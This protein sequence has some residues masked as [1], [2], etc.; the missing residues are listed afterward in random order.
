MTS[1]SFTEMAERHNAKQVLKLSR[2]LVLRLQ[3]LIEN[4]E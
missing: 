4:K 2:D 1:L 3:D